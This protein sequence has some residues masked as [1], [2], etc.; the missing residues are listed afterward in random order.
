[1][2]APMILALQPS[3]QHM[4]VRDQDE[5]SRLF[6]W[7]IRRWVTSMFRRQNP[8]PLL[9]SALQQHCIPETATELDRFMTDIAHNAVRK[10]EV[11]LTAGLELSG[12]EIILCRAI[13]AVANN[14]DLAIALMRL[15]VS[16]AGAIEA[17]RS[18]QQVS[19]AFRCGGLE[20]SGHPQNSAEPTPRKQPVAMLPAPVLRF[21]S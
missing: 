1:M 6:L 7:C 3:H 21:S 8:V 15:L 4:I 12:D 5:G 18:M 10:L 9:Q 2:E 19:A 17:V 11:R 20:L 16:Q 13:G 14:P